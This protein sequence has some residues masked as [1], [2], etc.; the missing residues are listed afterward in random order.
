MCYLGLYEADS[1]YHGTAQ[2]Y[3]DP[4]LDKA[5]SL[6]RHVGKHDRLYIEATAAYKDALK[7]AKPG[8]NFSPELQLWRELVKKYPRDT[9]KHGSSWRSIPV[10]KNRWRSYN[11]F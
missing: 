4:A 1:F 8:S 9:E 6:K 3:A 2:G 5:V 11:P 7:N 10:G